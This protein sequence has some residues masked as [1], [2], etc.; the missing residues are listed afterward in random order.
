MHRLTLFLI[1][2]FLLLACQN[3]TG[4]GATIQLK[5]SLDIER[6]D[7]LVKIPRALFNPFYTEKNSGRLPVLYLP[8][9]E[10][11]PIQFTDVDGDGNWDELLSVITFQPKEEKEINLKFKDSS[12]LPE[13][14]P[15]TDV[16]FGVGSSK[17]NVKEVQKY[18]RSGD[19]RKMRDS[20]FFQMEGPAWENDKVA[21]RI[22]F[23]PRNG[24]DIFGKTTD[25]LSLSKVGLKGNY[26]KQESWGMDILK[27]GNSLGAGSI[28][29]S[30]GDSLLRVTGKNSAIF[31]TLEE[32]PIKASFEIKYPQEDFDGNKIAVTHKI[33][34]Y[35]GQYFYES[36]VLFDGLSE[37]MNL[38]TGI[39]DLKPN[40]L[41]SSQKG[42]YFILSSYG[43]QSENDDDLGMAIIT[44]QDALITHGEAPDEGEGINKTHYLSI[45][46]NNNKHSKFYFFS[47][48]SQSHTGFSSQ[49]EFQNTLKKTANRLSH[50]IQVQM[51]PGGNR[52]TN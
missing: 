7:E 37:H 45:K 42:D 17:K 30:T 22:Y 11:L 29:I 23:D 3:K 43:K 4:Q 39:V 21:F 47:G 46:A 15:K 2:T 33:N 12:Q 41:N 25:T 10:A 32:G 5:N 14:E 6:P 26:H 19:P 24:I 44:K 8:E 40:T 20:L 31:K 9:N 51:S 28:A 38:A 50:P 35:Q 1:S 36:E 48:W 52:R 16:Y 18:T 34:I 27:V 49:K 13:F